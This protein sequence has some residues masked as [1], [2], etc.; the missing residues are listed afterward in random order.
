MSI[1]RCWWTTSRAESP[2]FEHALAPASRGVEVNLLQP[3]AGADEI[4]K[5][6]RLKPDALF[7]LSARLGD[8]GLTDFVAPGQFGVAEGVEHYAAHLAR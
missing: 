3:G 4:R 6:P 8:V 2:A 1:R 7:L 5:N